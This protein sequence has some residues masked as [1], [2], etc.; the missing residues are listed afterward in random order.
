MKHGHWNFYRGP[1]MID[2]NVQQVLRTAVNLIPFNL[3]YHIL[4]VI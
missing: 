4:F 2:S 1:Q 3:N